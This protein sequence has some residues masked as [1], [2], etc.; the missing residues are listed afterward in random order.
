MIEIIAD[1][2][3]EDK[4]RNNDN[5]SYNNDDDSYMMLKMIIIRG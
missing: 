2:I 5:Y 4:G 3:N 1:D